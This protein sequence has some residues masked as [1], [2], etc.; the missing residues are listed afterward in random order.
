MALI[1]VGITKEEI[2]ASAL[3]LKPGSY[4]MMYTGLLQDPQTS[5]VLWPTKAGG[6]MVKAKLQVV[7]NPDPAA[8][9]KMFIYNATIGSFTFSDLV[10]AIPAIMQG[11][12]IDD[13][14]GFGAI[15]S[16]QVVMGKGEYANQNNIKKIKRV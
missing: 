12:S 5:G 15:L 1:D 16:V 6:K 9:G 13:E 11:S 4:K 2:E 3:P 7:D 14:A 8:N 10:V